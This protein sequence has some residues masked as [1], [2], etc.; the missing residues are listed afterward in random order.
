[1]KNLRHIKKNLKYRNSGSTYPNLNYQIIDRVRDSLDKHFTSVRKT[2]M[3]TLVIDG[4][5]STQI[6]FGRI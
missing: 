5:K 1:M 3:N 6:K 2:S 4:V